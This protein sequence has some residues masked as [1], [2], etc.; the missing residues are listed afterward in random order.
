MDNHNYRIEAMKVAQQFSEFVENGHGTF[1]GVINNCLGELTI[2]A[3]KSGNVLL[4]TLKHESVIKIYNSEP[5][6]LSKISQY[7]RRNIF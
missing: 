4:F 5:K 1:V 2:T 7:M 6:V 3:I